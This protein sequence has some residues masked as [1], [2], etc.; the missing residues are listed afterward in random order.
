M[1]MAMIKPGIPQRN[2]QNISITNT[3]IIFMENDFPIKIG[4]K[5]AP[6]RTWTLV[7][8]TIKKNK[9]LVGSSSTKAKIER[10]M[11]AINEPTI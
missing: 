4:S 6:K 9:V 3:A 11:T 2:P 10:D 7:M 1:G 8:A 5:I